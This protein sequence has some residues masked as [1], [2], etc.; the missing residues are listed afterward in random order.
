MANLAPTISTFFIVLS[1]ICIAIGWPHAKKKN[2]QAHIRWMV[3]AA[4][5]ATLFFIVYATRTVFIGNTKFGGPESVETYYQIFLIFHIIL[6]TVGG[7]LGGISLWTGYKKRY[8]FHK[9]L[10]PWT[11]YIW[12]GTAI[13]GVMVYLLLYVI[14][15]PGPTDSVIK[16]ILGF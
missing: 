14:Y 10:G 12:F 3:M 9:K 4:V 15:P 13:T 16:V 7:V 2:I 8:S 5:F 6:A 1:A 11:S